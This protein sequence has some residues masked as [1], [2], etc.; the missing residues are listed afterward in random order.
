VIVN[1]NYNHKIV[2]VAKLLLPVVAIIDVF[3]AADDR[4][5]H[6]LACVCVGFF[7]AVGVG[8][9]GV[10]PGALSTSAVWVLLS[11]TGAWLDNPPPSPPVSA[12][13][14]V[15]SSAW[16]VLPAHCVDGGTLVTTIDRKVVPIRTLQ[17]GDSVLAFKRGKFV[18]ARIVEVTSQRVCSE[19]MCRIV[20][21]SSQVVIATRNHAFWVDGK[22][23]CSVM[24]EAGS[25]AKKLE[26]GDW[27]VDLCG[28]KVQVQAIEDVAAAESHEVFNLLLEGSGSWFANGILTHSSM[29]ASAKG[30][31]NAPRRMI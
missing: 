3:G 8:A 7:P 22:K 30:R 9:W 29:R 17:K 2:M 12:G 19:H 26:L 5:T 24:P 18:S 6:Q 15:I 20:F 13:G 16:L 14:A 1:R 27:C 31:E 21:S 11:L 23:W 10:G 28:K 25:R 4:K